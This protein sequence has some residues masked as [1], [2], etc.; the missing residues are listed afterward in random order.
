MF[1]KQIQVEGLIDM[2]GLSKKEDQKTILEFSSE[3]NEDHKEYLNKK[4]WIY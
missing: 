2:K 3:L 1:G 4:E